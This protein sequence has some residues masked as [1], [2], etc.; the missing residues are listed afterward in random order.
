MTKQKD[1][2]CP[3]CLQYFK[4]ALEFAPKKFTPP[5]KGLRGYW[6][7]GECGNLYYLC[8]TCAGRM[9]ARGCSIGRNAVP[10]W[11]NTPEPYGVCIG[12]NPPQPLPDFDGYHGGDETT[13]FPEMV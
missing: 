12:C 13:V 8:A 6:V 1:Q 2:H 3:V 10:V 11:S 9:I 4:N 5:P 7:P